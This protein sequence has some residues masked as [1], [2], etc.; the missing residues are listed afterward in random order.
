MNRRPYADEAEYV[1]NRPPLA[2]MADYIQSLPF[3]AQLHK[4]TFVNYL[5]VIIDPDGVV[6]Y[7]VPFIDVMMLR[8]AA[9]ATG[10]TEQQIIDDCPKDYYGDWLTYL[11][12]LSGCV[13]VQDDR[14]M[15]YRLTMAQRD[16]LEMLSQ[17]GLYGGYVPSR[18]ETMD[19]GKEDEQ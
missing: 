17:E 3:D 6:E 7:A 11:S 15:G 10:Q 16:S 2:D 5:R 18:E 8:K 4:L 12:L 1:Q 13:A 19:T 9:K 14:C